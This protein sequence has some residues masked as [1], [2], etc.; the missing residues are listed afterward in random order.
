MLVASGL[1]SSGAARYAPPKASAAATVIFG[2]HCQ[3]LIVL[4]VR[5]TNCSSLGQPRL[6][7]KMGICGRLLLVWGCCE[8]AV[9]RQLC[10]S[11]RPSSQAV[12]AMLKAQGASL[13][14]AASSASCARAALPGTAAAAALAS[15]VCWSACCCEVSAALSAAASEELCLCCPSFPAALTSPSAVWTARHFCASKSSTPRAAVGCLV[16][17]RLATGLSGLADSPKVAVCGTVKRL[18]AKPS[19]ICGQCLHDKA[20]VTRAGAVGHSQLAVTV[21]SGSKGQQ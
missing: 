19:Q 20:V 15:S 8:A 9:M 4:H 1:S 3:V 2:E 17:K 5:Q 16:P 7:S 14:G 21:L 11:T 12:Q 13:T 6:L 10:T 18:P